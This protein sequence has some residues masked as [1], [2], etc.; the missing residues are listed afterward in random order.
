[1]GWGRRRRGEKTGKSERQL[2]MKNRTI[3]Y[4]WKGFEK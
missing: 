4:S 2:L 1:M 3:D